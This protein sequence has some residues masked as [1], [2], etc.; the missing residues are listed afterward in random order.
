MNRQ[1]NE[2][3]L[4]AIAPDKLGSSDSL[5]KDRAVARVE[6]DNGLGR[7]III[8]T[9]LLIVGLLIWSWFTE[10]EEIAKAPGQLIPAEEVQ[11][12]RAPFDS[13]V[14]SI[15]VKAGDSVKCGQT[16][17]E[18][19]TKTYRAELERYK[20]ELS[21]AEQQLTRH[22][23]ALQALT[24]YLKD[25]HALSPDHSSITVVSRAIG[26]VYAAQQR[27]D[28]ALLDMKMTK[29][30]K[31]NMPE[32][33]VLVSQQQHISEQRRL[34]EQA[35]EERRKQFQVE[36]DSL[37]GQIATLTR[38]IALQKASVEQ[39]RYSLECAQKQLAAYE[40][41][42]TTGASS[43]T[44][45]LDATMRVEDRK[46]ELT[47]A[48][49]KQRE[50]EGQLA[51]TMHELAQLQSKNS[52]QSS[53]LKAGVSEIAASEAEVNMRLRSSERNLSDAQT[54]FQ[55]ALRGAQSTQASENVEISNLS[56]QIEQ[57]K[58]SIASED[59]TLLKG[60]LKAP[61]DGKVALLHVQ[62][63]G[64]VVQYGQDLLTIV[65]TQEK[66]V[67]CLHVP[68]DQIAFLNQNEQVKMQF[69]AYPHTQYGTIPGVIKLIDK[70]PSQEKEYAG[71][72]K[73]LLTPER[74]WIF[75]RGKKIPLRKGLQVEA[76]M[77]LRRKRLLISIL[78]P[79]L[80]LQ[81]TH[82]KA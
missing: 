59:H 72:F 43:K 67:A 50:Y 36:Q 44:E 30:A 34:K 5:S 69:P 73:V 80:K 32:A 76:E 51:T 17:L 65:P 41:A 81:Y 78:E 25:T 60:S 1:D 33:S 49:A 45:C 66:L 22:Q 31:S 53:Q 11:P 40:K 2:S 46:H 13:K 68:N 8:M 82:F 71:S 14:L 29:L 23:H 35:L 64:E 16:L 18:L 27:L 52:I 19:D 26:D 10:L 28:R 20:H 3:N 75:C 57:L 4:L 42:F 58:A 56:K 39:R 74:N 24:K 15:S 70:F 38:Q 9:L 79:L 61:V 21:D 12:I 55:V 48:E 62:G 47:V 54:A 63:S 7:K 6:F 77:V 37:E